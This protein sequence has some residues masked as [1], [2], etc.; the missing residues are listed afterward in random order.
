[1]VEKKTTTKEKT[2][3]KPAVAKTV[4]ITKTAKAV[5][6]EKPVKKSA[7]QYI[8]Q[9]GKRKNA[10]ASVRMFAKGKG[11]ITVNG[12]PLERYFD[13]A[14]QKKVVEQPIK[15][16]GIKDADFTILAKGG[17]KNGQADAVR[18]AITKILIKQDSALRPILKAKGWLKRDPRVK[19]RKKPGLKRA[20]RAP[21]WS[22]R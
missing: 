3:K 1:M 8:A 12:Q 4:K 15:Q 16:V 10:T 19:E 5:K 14:Y 6:A 2:V 18:L 22:K 9:M 21:Q 11:L 7:N 13:N 20:R 17:G